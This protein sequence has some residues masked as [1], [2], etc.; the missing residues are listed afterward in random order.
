MPSMPR[1]KG[2]A[3]SIAYSILGDPI[4]MPMKRRKNRPKPQEAFEQSDHLDEGSINEVAQQI[5][6]A[7]NPGFF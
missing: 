5:P 7:E 2:K 4:N 6:T 1:K 3:T